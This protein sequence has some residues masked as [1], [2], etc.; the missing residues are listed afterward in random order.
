MLSTFIYCFVEVMIL[1]LYKT[2]RSSSFKSF[3]NFHGDNKVVRTQHD[4]VKPKF[5]LVLKEPQHI[6][7]YL[8]QTHGLLIKHIKPQTARIYFRNLRALLLLQNLC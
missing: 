6:S 4:V 5:L 2:R 7:S 1:L 3:H 8:S